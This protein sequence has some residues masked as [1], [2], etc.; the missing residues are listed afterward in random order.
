MN[1]IGLILGSIFIIFVPGYIWS[2]VFFPIGAKDLG[3]NIDLLERIAISI[4][5]SLTLIP[6]FLFGINTFITISIDLTSSILITCGVIFAGLIVLYFRS[7]ETLRHGITSI[8][9]LVSG[10][11]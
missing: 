3:K 1:I 7:L 6:L 11:K 9:R 8:G 5:I 4:G 2:Y 10:K